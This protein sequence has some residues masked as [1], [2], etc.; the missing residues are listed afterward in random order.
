MPFRQTPDPDCA[1]Q[2]VS[3]WQAEG[4]TVGFVP[5]MGA[6]HE[7]HLSLIRASVRECD[8]TVVSIYVNPTQFAPGEDLDKYPRRLDADLRLAEQAGAHLVFCPTDEVMYPAGHAT[9]VAQERLTGVLE[10]RARPT[11][12]RGVLTVVCKLLHIVPADRAYFGQKDFQQTVVIRRM[13]RDLNIPAVIRVMPTVREPDG[14]AMSSRNECLNAE[15]RRQAACLYR[16]L[17]EGRRLYRT[18]EADP[19]AIRAA[20]ERIIAEAPLARPDYVEVVDGE[21]LAPAERVT[22]RAVAVLAV[23]MGRTRLIDNL[24]FAE[25]PTDASAGAGP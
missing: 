23:R 3:R 11:H 14:L 9:Y 22:D 2:A 13:V 25:M 15:E 17:T 10:G 5:T 18:G 24:P 7:G 6:F 19:D 12:F 1:R 4:L 21:T 8:R 20:M 16:A